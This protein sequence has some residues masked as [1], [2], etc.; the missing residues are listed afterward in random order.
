MYTYS[1]II[2]KNKNKLQHYM[3]WINTTNVMIMKEAQGKDGKLYNLN[4]LNSLQSAT[5]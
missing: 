4:L 3:T 1:G 5:N 2:D